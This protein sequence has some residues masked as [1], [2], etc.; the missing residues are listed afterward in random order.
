MLADDAGS[1]PACPGLSTVKYKPD[2]D[3]AWTE[4]E[5][6]LDCTLHQQVTT[7]VYTIDDFNFETPSTDLK[8][9]SGSGALKAYEYPGRFAAK[10]DGESRATTWLEGCETFGRLIRGSSSARSFI[11]GYTVSLTGHYRDERPIRVIC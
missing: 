10:S 7:E 6:V 3:Q 9:E 8:S 4:S 1:Q 11:A 5:L 2:G